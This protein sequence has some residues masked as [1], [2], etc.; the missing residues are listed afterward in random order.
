MV[1]VFPD[2]RNQN[3]SREGG[4]PTR[5]VATRRDPTLTHASAKDW[6]KP[7]GCILIST[8]GKAEFRPLNTIF[9]LEASWKNR[10][11]LQGLRPTGESRRKQIKYK[12]V[13]YTVQELVGRDSGS[14]GD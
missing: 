2:L 6:F 7:T 12:Y 4:P 9:A 11:K 13:L 8:P 10:E 1:D 5:R 14:D 3:T